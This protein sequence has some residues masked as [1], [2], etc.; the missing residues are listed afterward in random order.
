MEWNFL[1]RL[2]DLKEQGEERDLKGVIF[3][4]GEELPTVEQIEDFLRET[5]Y[6]VQ[7]Q[8][9]RQLTF[10]DH[11]RENPVKITIVKLER[12]DLQQEEMQ[13]DL[14]LRLL[15]EQFRKEK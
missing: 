7:L 3:T 9:D 2:D 10:L 8:D 12:A 14:A 13:P 1:F 5:G 4:E 6:A 11:N 15:A